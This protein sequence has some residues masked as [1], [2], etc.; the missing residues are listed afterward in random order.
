MIN[1]VKN[2]Y[3]KGEAVWIPSLIDLGAWLYGSDGLRTLLQN[4]MGNYVSK[5]PFT[6]AEPQNDVMI[7]T[8]QNGGRYVTVIINQ[9]NQNAK[10]VLQYAVQSKP[11]VIF[12]NEIAFDP[13][14]KSVS[15]EPNET[16]V[17][18]WE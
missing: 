5:L 10:V 13:A 15:L 6:F 2:K 16:I 18:L 4:E 12:E 9:Q 7:R 1:L 14:A 8:L 11:R 3:G 17:I